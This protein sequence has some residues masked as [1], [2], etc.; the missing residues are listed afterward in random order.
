MQLCKRFVSRLLGV[1]GRGK[2]RG[3]ACGSGGGRGRAHSSSLALHRA[4]AGLPMAAGHKLREQHAFSLAPMMDY[5]DHHQHYFFRLLTR[6]AVL[7]TEMVTA[8]A[9]NHNLEPQKL[10][11][12]GLSVNG[13][14]ERD[15]SQM[16][17]V[18]C[19]L[20]GSDVVAMREAA[21]VA[22]ALGFR[23]FNINCGCPSPKVAGSGQ[24][25][26]SLM[27]NP[28]T[29]RDIC[30]AVSDESGEP[31]TVKMRIGLDR[32]DDEECYAFTR[33]FVDVVS[34]TDSGSSSDSA[35]KHFIVHARKAILDKKLTPA[36]NRRI[37]PLRHAFVHKLCS[38][39]PQLAF[40]INGGFTSL[41]QVLNQLAISDDMQSQAAF[42]SQDKSLSPQLSEASPLAGV[43]IGRACV[44]HP[45]QWSVVDSHL[46]NTPNQNFTRREI[47]HKYAEYAKTVELKEGSRSRHCVT[48]PI[49]RLFTGEANGR[50]FRSTLDSLILKGK[51]DGAVI[52]ID[53]VIL[54]AAEAVGEDVLDI[55]P[56]EWHHKQQQLQ[57]Q[58]LQQLQQPV[59]LHLE[60]RQ[61]QQH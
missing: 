35:V 46:Y 23:H 10:F 26:A 47:L 39:Y 44:D 28:E 22:C 15:I 21:R 36:D 27:H 20:G 38:D 30:R 61:Q 9:L 48:K 1:R 12:F 43:M 29:V 4:G 49:L 51:H 56:E 53:Q 14:S 40:S 16:E 34:G 17:P 60:Q 50:L 59:Q 7:Y 41:Q 58:Q 25:G 52:P 42:I 3:T 31:T 57:L 33:K 13:N 11:G 37:P 6:Q 8:A 5:T 19:Q 54:Q 2:G 45:F 24:F 55:T 32:M 18:V